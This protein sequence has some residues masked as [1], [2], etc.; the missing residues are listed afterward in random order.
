[1]KSLWSRLFGHIAA[2]ADFTPE[3]FKRLLMPFRRS[4]HVQRYAASVIIA[5]VQLISTIFSVLVPLWSIVDLLVFDMTT[6]LWLTMLRLG[7]AG[8]FV[9]LAWPRKIS[10]IYPYFQAITMLIVMVMVPV[11]FY[12]ISL[13]VLDPKGMVGA[14]ALMIRAYAFMP[15]IVLGGLAIFPLTALEIILLSVPVL[16]IM[17]VSLAVHGMSLSIEEHATALWCM[18]MLMGVSIFSGMSQSFYMETLVQRAMTDSLTGTFSRRSGSETLELIFRLSQMSG[19]PLALAFFDLD[20]FKHIN[21]MFGHEAGDQTLK[22]TVDHLRAMLRQGDTLVRWGGEEFVAILP[23]LEASQLQ[24]FI[25]RVKILGLGQS[26]DGSALTVSV[27]IAERVADKI[28]N[29][30]A[31]VDLAD[32]RMYKAKHRGRHRAVLPG[33][34]TVMLTED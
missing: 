30:R 14:E 21:D 26:P 4:A 28:A 6:A 18:L 23:N 9:I 20:H 3:Q 7:S 10:S 8:I 12:L 25:E 32:Q 17:L 24:S 16:A 2:S 34:V 29:W 22:Q 27:G 13:T 15:T 33:D 11:T 19:R 1:M 5:R 31:L